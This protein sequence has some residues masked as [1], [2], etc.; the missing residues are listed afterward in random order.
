[1]KRT[2]YEPLELD[3]VLARLAAHTAFSASRELALALEPTPDF[4]EA[5]RR[6]AATTE[7]RQLLAQRPQTSVGAAQDIRPLVARAAVGGV[8]RPEELRAIAATAHAAAVLRTTLLSAADTRPTLA[9][10][11]RRL[12]DHAAVREAIERS[13]GDGGEVLD[14]ASAELRRL[15]A[16]VRAAYDR[17]MA[18]L[19]E[20]LASPEYR[21]ALQEPLITMRAGR[22]VL[23]I[24]VE[25]RH[26]VRGIVHDQS[27]SGATLFIEPLAVLDLT[28]RWREL[29]IAEE[30]E[31]ERVLQALSRLVGDDR[32][33]L[34]QSVAALAELDLY[35][36]MARLAE[37][38]RATA[39]ALYPL[40]PSREP[41]DGRA[42]A[43]EPPR[44]V[45]RLRA[46][47]H[48]LLT[49]EVVPIDVELGG[50]FDIL[51]ITGPNTGGKTVALK[52]I[53][54]LALMAQ[55]GLHLPAAEGSF[56]SVFAGVY[57]DIGDEQSIEQSLSTFS[58]HLTRII[59]ILR[60][61]DARSL[62]LLDEL[63]A[64]TDPQE[65][66]ALARALLDELRA[67]GSYVVATTHY[68]ELKSYAHLTP[69][70]ENASVEFDLETLS[71]T[72][73]LSIGLPG[74][75]N[76]LAIAARLGLPEP[77]IARARALLSPAAVEVEQ[78]LDEIQREREA[79]ARARA[80]AE[81]AAA[82]AQRLLE[83]RERQARAV[84]E[85]REAIWR[86]ARRESEAM[87]AELRRQ[88]ERELAAARAAR[89]D[90][91]AL[92]AVAERAA[93]L[94]P[95]ET[96]PSPHGTRPRGRLAAP[97]RP[98][99]HVGA[100]VGVPRLNARGTIRSLSDDGRQ[101][102][103]EVGGLRV[104]LPT[105]ELAAPE[106]VERGPADAAAPAVTYVPA[107]ALPAL[108]RPVPL[109]LDVRGQRVADALEAVERYLD[110]AYR[111]GLRAVRIVHGH[112]TGAVRQAVRELLAHH[113]H[114][115]RWSPADPRQGG[116]GA[117][118]VELAG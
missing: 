20:L 62:V 87:L 47:R 32:Y 112:G 56:T 106:A 117:T 98:A 40:E 22:Y 17:L 92:Q 72:Y 78:L 89:A 107:P 67:R 95:L 108:D 23:P 74:R 61:A 84:D 6:Q 109:Q 45:L 69:R 63:G 57:A 39:P 7:A 8:L 101:A 31:I 55:C 38:Q 116:D 100:R 59:G 114:V 93:A 36:A 49:G 27:A 71:P 52:T 35:L 48:P 83:R 110:D 43:T 60:E 94:A 58:S 76:A 12:G 85:E 42:R 96:P 46:A 82:E 115:A 3:K 33:G 29:Q 80:Q 13:I 70:V 64:G 50:A 9:A 34:E 41:G 10:V 5:Q 118:E 44:P 26:Q 51:V 53:G 105:S 21:A 103:V 11:A 102:E 18:K 66:A 104:R 111:A 4:A 25:A 79:A 91:T 1:V 73:R 30:R 77:V 37:E 54:L 15:R 90:R 28:N 16:Q 75:S 19:Q 14:T 65:G 97:Q 86:R 113:P 81:R 68:P 99:L 24:K 88:I 2:D